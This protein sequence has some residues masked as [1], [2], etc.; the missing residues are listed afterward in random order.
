[1]ATSLPDLRS[2]VLYKTVAIP[3]RHFPAANKLFS[4]SELS[5]LPVYMAQHGWISSTVPCLNVLLTFLVTSSIF[6]SAVAGF[7]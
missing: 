5:D 6:S 2:Q 3:S 4:A 1:M 7:R